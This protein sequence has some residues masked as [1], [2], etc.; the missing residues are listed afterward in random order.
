MKLIFLDVD[1]VLNDHQFS[2]RAGSCSITARCVRN[3]NLLLDATGAKIVL[4]S[5]W[6]YMVPGAMSLKGFEY[7]L[8]THGVVAGI[9]IVGATPRDE[10]V[11]TR[12][13][14]ISEWIKANG[15]PEA[16]VVIDDMQ[17]D[18]QD[19]GHPLVM[20][21]GFDGLKDADVRQAIR[22]LN[23]EL[24]AAARDEDEKDVPNG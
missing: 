20:T 9:E 11:P 3:F 17:F 23:G 15:E 13:Q 10:E 19:W 18:I 16:Y 6:R 1:G 4:S 22:I 7:L 14:Q 2:E 12:G 21:E 5:A 24:V 8:R